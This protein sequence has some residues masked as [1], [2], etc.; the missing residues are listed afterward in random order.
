MYYFVKVEPIVKEGLSNEFYVTKAAQRLAV[1]SGR[2]KLE[3]PERTSI[4]A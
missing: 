4:E 2:G 3:F 1:L